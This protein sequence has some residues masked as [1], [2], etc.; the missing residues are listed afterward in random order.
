[1]LGLKQG[2][3]SEHAPSLKL[4]TWGLEGPQH[5]PPPPRLVSAGLFRDIWVPGSGRGR[6]VGGRGSSFIRCRINLPPTLP[7]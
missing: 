7:G 3:P 4:Q 2:V 5:P 1:M 6:G